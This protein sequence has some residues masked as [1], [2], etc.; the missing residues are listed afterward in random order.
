[1]D[2]SVVIPAYN[3]EKYLAACLD[4]LFGAEGID[5]TEIIIVDDGSTDGT[6]KIACKYASDHKNIKVISKENGGPSSSRNAG[7]KEA[8]GKYVFFCDA[9]D[10]VVPELFG[11]VIS[12]AGISLL[13][14]VSRKQSARTAGKRYLRRSLETAVILSPRSG[15]AHIERLF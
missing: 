3:V 12:L 2:L 8:T 15:S 14:A 6:R 4:S 11:R 7:L 5:G 9:D 13:T 10:M 1:M